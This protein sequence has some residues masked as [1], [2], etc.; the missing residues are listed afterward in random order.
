[1]TL[2]RER[3]V[4]L[5][6]HAGASAALYRD[7]VDRVGDGSRLIF[8]PVEL[9]GRGSRVREPAVLDL[10]ALAGRLAADI[11]ADW[12][13]R[14]KDEARDWVTFGH[15]FGG[16]LSVLVAHALSERYG[17]T[18]EVSLVSCSVPP[19]RQPEDDRHQW[20]DDRILQQAAADGATP[21]AVLN[22]PVMARQ[23][24]SQMRADYTIRHQFLG[25]R[26]LAVEQPLRLIAANGDEHVTVETVRAWRH[27]TRAGTELVRID[28]DHFAVYHHFTQVCRELLRDHRQITTV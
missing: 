14:P 12:S 15:S 20:S 3:V 22:E 25:Y 19:C 18:P 6:P 5:F 1:M 7:W 28:G 24:V 4:Y 2:A 10:P 13:A 9:P 23:V 17:M 27:H 16:V 11:H 21:A 26:D 8:C